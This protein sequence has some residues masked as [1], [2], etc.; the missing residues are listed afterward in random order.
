MDSSIPRNI[1]SER[2]SSGRGFFA[3][4]VNEGTEGC[5]RGCRPLPKC[6]KEA[7]H[8]RTKCSQH[9]YEWDWA[10]AEREF[11][12]A[13]KLSPD[14]GDAYGLYAWYLA[15]LGRKDEAI[16]TAA[17]AQRVDPLSL[18]GNFGPGSISVFT[19]QWG[20]ATQ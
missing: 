17:Q 14:N 6:L 2:D 11:K 9:W 4:E 15:A 5:G 8:E 10:A 16:A 19:R 18:L 3:Y 12:Q 13:L 20:L 7:Q 1:F